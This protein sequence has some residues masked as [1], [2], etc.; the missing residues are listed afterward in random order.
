[1]A[2]HPFH[3]ISNS[4][5]DSAERGIIRL[6]NHLL[7]SFPLPFL[8]ACFTLCLYLFV[9]I[10]RRRPQRRLLL[11]GYYLALPGIARRLRLRRPPLLLRVLTLTLRSP[12]SLVLNSTNRT[13]A[14]RPARVAADMFGTMSSAIPS[15]PSAFD[16]V[17]RKDRRLST[18]H[19]GYSPYRK[20][21]FRLSH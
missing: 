16:T 5:S 19:I 17:W 8:S 2:S 10:A 7:E 15:C 12:D 13:S 4:L 14:P 21:R 18:I 6:R 3:F 9:V 1:M 11:P 20:A